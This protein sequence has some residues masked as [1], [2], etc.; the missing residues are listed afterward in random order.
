MPVI[1]ITYWNCARKLKK[2]K[3]PC[4]HQWYGTST[5]E[6]H[7][8]FGGCSLEMIQQPAHV[9]NISIV[10]GNIHLAIKTR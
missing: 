3:R 7:G 9:W 2:E 8:F 5:T 4:Q 10:P 6:F 1:L